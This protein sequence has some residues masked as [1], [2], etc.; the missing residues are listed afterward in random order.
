M[1]RHLTL[2]PR[3][4]RGEPDIIRSKGAWAVP[5]LVAS[6]QNRPSQYPSALECWKRPHRIEE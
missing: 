4:F 1:I 5:L 3:S 2:T 6:K